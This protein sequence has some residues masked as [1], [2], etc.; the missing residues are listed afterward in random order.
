MKRMKFDN[1]VK[2]EISKL[3]GK[4]DR[5]NL[6]L[7]LENMISNIP[8]KTYFKLGVAGTNEYYVAKFYGWLKGGGN[9]PFSVFTVGNMKLPFLNF[10]TLPAVTCGGAGDCLNWCYSFKAWRYP[11]AFLRQCMNT[12]LMFE[13][14]TIEAEL[15]KITSR[16]KFAKLDKIDFRLY[17]DG[18][19]HTVENLVDWME[20]M[21]KMPKINSYG[22]SKSLNHF[23]TL[24]ESGFK[25]P[26]N[27]VLNLSSGGIYESLNQFLQP[28]PFVR[29]EFKA[30]NLNGGTWSDYRKQNKNKK[31]FVCPLKCGECTSIGHACGNLSTF[32]NYDIVIAQH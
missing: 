21:R 6:L 31:I 20:L 22:Y 4:N 9:L 1:V 12:L 23:F 32:K 18:D 10:S 5:K 14:D 13:F 2:T 11:S 17:V 19:F 28:L 16:P 30:V 25:F 27:Y 26:V 15:I 29:G 24:H 8:P 7:Y 3:C